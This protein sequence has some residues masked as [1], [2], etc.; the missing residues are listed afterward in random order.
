MNKKLIFSFAFFL[1]LTCGAFAGPPDVAGDWLTKELEGDE[2]SRVGRFLGCDFIDEGPACGTSPQY[3]NVLLV[4]RAEVS[5][6]TNRLA[7]LKLYIVGDF[8]SQI[9]NKLPRPF[10]AERREIVFT[11]QVKSQ[12][13]VP[14]QP[15]PRFIDICSAKENF[16][17]RLTVF[18]HKGLSSEILEQELAFIEKMPESTCNNK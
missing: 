10:K 9:N 2:A 7:N 18:G 11:F 3:E 12:R 14:S 6:I 5:F 1:L 8:S 13:L 15:I 16:K 17:D 4:T